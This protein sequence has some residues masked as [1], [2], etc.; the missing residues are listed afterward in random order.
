MAE[1]ITE[2][3]S[4]QQ[5]AAEGEQVGVDHPGEVGHREVQV[6]PDGGQGDI[7][8]RVVDQEHE[9]G[10]AGQEQDESGARSAHDFLH[11]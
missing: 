6:A 4:K 1:E 3:P 10:D 7:G 8:D 11:L 2:S 9:L 5:E